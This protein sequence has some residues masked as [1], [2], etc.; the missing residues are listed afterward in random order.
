LKVVWS[1]KSV[2]EIGDHVEY[3]AKDSE[4]TAKAWA[5]SLFRRVEGLLE[6]PLVGRL[7]KRGGAR[8]IRE[9]VIDSDF[10][11]TYRV[12]KKEIQVLAFFHAVRKRG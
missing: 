4:K 6:F 9:L 8:G 1:P 11:L 7:G 2:A 12:R 5:E 3:I 10:L